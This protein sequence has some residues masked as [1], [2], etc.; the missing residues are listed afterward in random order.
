MNPYLIYVYCVLTLG[1][2]GLWHV[3]PLPNILYIVCTYPWI[4]WT[5]TCWIHPLYTVHCVYLPLDPLDSDMLNPSL[6]Y[7]IMS[8]YC[9]YLP[10]DPLDSDMMNPYLIYCILCIL[11]VGSPG[12][13]HDEPVPNKR[14]TNY[15]ITTKIVIVKHRQHWRFQTE[16]CKIL[17]IVIKNWVEVASIK[18]YGWYV[19]SKS[20][21]GMNGNIKRFLKDNNRCLIPLLKKLTVPSWRKW[22]ESD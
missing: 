18:R 22:M 15:L 21:R 19:N 12:L 13:W 3:E 7:C 9:V 5:L 6:I 1:S 10:L 8:V 2:P 16:R 20:V 11:T 4:P 17:K 14:A